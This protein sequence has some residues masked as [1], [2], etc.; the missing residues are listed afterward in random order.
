VFLWSI[1]EQKA[2][3]QEG[4]TSDGR[5]GWLVPRSYDGFARAIDELCHGRA[6]PYRRVLMRAPG[7]PFTISDV[8]ACLLGRNLWYP[9]LV[10][11]RDWLMRSGERP[12]L[13]TFE[14]TSS[15]LWDATKWSQLSLGARVVRARA[16]AVH[17]RIATITSATAL[18]VGVRQFKQG[19]DELARGAY[20]D[21]ATRVFE[22]IATPQALHTDLSL[23][24]I[25][26]HWLVMLQHRER[27]L[28]DAYAS[29][30]EVHGY[31]EACSLCRERW[32]LRPFEAS[33]VPPFHPGCRCFAQPRFAG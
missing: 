20:Y 9:S 12:H 5:N 15:C 33:W 13:W 2:G 24:E 22:P 28:S 14:F 21:P 4:A 32:G 7:S 25:L 10:T 18:Q 3:P 26:S 16:G 29:G 8:A 30:F 27:V 19:L 31:A 11:F 23:I 6:S 1:H 17:H